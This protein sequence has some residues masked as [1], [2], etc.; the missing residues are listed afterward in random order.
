[1]KIEATLLI[2]PLL[3]A[4]SVTVWLPSYAW[5]APLSAV[6]PLIVHLVKDWVPDRSA[7]FVP[8]PLNPKFKDL[9]VAMAR[10]CDG[11]SYNGKTQA[12][13]LTAYCDEK[14]ETVPYSIDWDGKAK[15]LIVVT[16][17]GKEQLTLNNAPFFLMPL[18]IR[19]DESMA[20]YFIPNKQNSRCE[21]YVNH[22][23]LS[24]AENLLIDKTK[25]QFRYKLYLI[26]LLSLW[27][28]GDWHGK[29]G[30]LTLAI[31]AIA[32]LLISRLLL[33]LPSLLK[34]I[35]SLFEF[36]VLVIRHRIFK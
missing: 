7:I 22:P 28:F 6:I 15:S 23:L 31:F 20:L 36:A 1:M 33:F 13:Y 30:F 18:P 19:V 25:E 16:Q 24:K 11:A 5:L 8:D 9:L 2:T 26:L 12:I 17:N 4:A 29:P 27:L 35:R 10:H 32:P 3:L 14:G 34:N 21:I